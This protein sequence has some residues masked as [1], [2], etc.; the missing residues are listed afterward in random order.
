MKYLFATLICLILLS[1]QRSEFKTVDFD[2]F[3]I[4]VP[5]NWQKHKI[6]GIDSYVGGLI[7]DRNDTLIFDLGWYSPDVSENDFPLVFDSIGLSE[8]S[9]KELELLP[10]TNHLIVDSLS[11]D[12]EFSKYLHYQTEIDTIDCF[13]AKLITPKNKGFGATGIYIDSLT[14]GDTHYNKVK[15]GF[16]GNHLSDSTQAEFVKAL[17]NI[18]FKKYC[19]QQWL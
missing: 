19:S 15:F 18:K 3:E 8:L 12:I 1:C 14:G 7:T 17:R 4:T 9:K 5:S 16:Y 2:V 13:I 10:K 11:G 6:K